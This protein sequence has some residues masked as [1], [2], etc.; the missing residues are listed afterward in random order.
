M[1]C[2]TAG[3]EDPFELDSNLLV[4]SD[5]LGEDR[6]RQLHLFV[7]TLKHRYFGTW[8]IY[9]TTLVLTNLWFASLNKD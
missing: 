8:L 3:Q 5:P 7:T 9:G 1:S 2:T 6:K 4:L